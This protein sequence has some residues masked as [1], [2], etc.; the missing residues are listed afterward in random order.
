LILQTADVNELAPSI[1]RVEISLDFSEFLKELYKR[2]TANLKE[3]EASQ[4]KDLLAENQDV[5]SK[6]DT[7][8]GCFYLVKFMIDTGDATPIRQQMRRSLMEY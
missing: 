8:L 4:V 7:D 2:S 3:D 1:H 6:G 5:F